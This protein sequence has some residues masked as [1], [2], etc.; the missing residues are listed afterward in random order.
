M[1]ILILDYLLSIIKL[2]EPNTRRP[3]KQ[4]SPSL[5]GN[6]TSLESAGPQFDDVE[7][8]YRKSNDAKAIALRKVSVEMPHSRVKGLVRNGGF[9]ARPSQCYSKQRYRVAI[10][11][12]SPLSTRSFE[13]NQVDYGSRQCNAQFRIRR[14]RV[15]DVYW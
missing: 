8:R 2:C 11:N 12:I 4:S 13:L 3:F 14:I 15:L 10:S 5:Q 7:D 6:S 1:G 9:I